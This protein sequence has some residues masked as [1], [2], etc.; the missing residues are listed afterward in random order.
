MMITSPFN[1]ALFSFTGCLLLASCGTTPTEQKAETDQ[2]LEKIEDKMMDA[3]AANTQAAWENE[4]TVILNDLRQLRDDIDRKLANTNEKLA[5]TKLKPSDR[6]D[7]EALKTELTREKNKVEDL[8]VKAENATDA[9]W[10]S[11]KAEIETSSEEVKGWWARQKE[12][13][14]KKTTVDKDNDG[15]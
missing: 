2:K 8:I 1:L 3:S 13:V 6:N 5:D 12:K 7:H 9:T 11:A 14:D 4:R 15:H 10:S